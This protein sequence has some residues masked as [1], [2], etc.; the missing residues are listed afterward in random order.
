MDLYN[1]LYIYVEETI[2]L[3]KIMKRHEQID[4]CND[5]YLRPY[6]K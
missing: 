1:Y 4:S 6:N 2:K 5:K 3:V